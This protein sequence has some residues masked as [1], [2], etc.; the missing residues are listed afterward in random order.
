[1][2]SLSERDELAKKLCHSDYSTAA[3]IYTRNTGRKLHYRYLEKFIK[4][5]RKCTG[6]KPG[7]HQPLEMYRAL[8]EAYRQ[9]ID[10]EKMKEAE[11]TAQARNIR[12]RLAA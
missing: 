7:A 2:I 8:A 11:M 3:S 12:E 5:E 6:K 1:M 10:A 4:G 9:R